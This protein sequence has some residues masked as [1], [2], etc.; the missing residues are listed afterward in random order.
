MWICL[1]CMNTPLNP[2]ADYLISRE[3]RDITYGLFFLSSG[4]NQIIC[5][6]ASRN[7]LKFFIHLVHIK[8]G[9]IVNFFYLFFMKIN[10]ILFFSLKIFLFFSKSPLPPWVLIG[11]PLTGKGIIWFY[12]SII[13][14]TYQQQKQLVLTNP[15]S[16]VN[17]LHSKLHQPPPKYPPTDSFFCKNF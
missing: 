2:L 15:H 3:S 16:S 17:S 5:S 10:N 7:H 8:M 9:Q 11:R 1:E 6:S 14:M 13:I 12:K 4:T